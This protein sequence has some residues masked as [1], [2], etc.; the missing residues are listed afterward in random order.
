M[1]HTSVA[2]S[3]AIAGPPRPR[4]ARLTY[5]PSLYI[6]IEIAKSV[7]ASQFRALLHRERAHNVTGRIWTETDYIEVMSSSELRRRRPQL[8]ASTLRLRREKLLT[9]YC[10]SDLGGHD[11]ASDGARADL[12]WYGQQPAVLQRAK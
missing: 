6:A 4:H 5:F 10:P 12:L 8:M 11:H 7:T 3:T 2:G 1:I 9:E